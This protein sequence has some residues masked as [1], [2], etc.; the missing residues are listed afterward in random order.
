MAGGQHRNEIKISA[1]FFSR[2][3]L[4]YNITMDRG[5]IVPLALASSAQLRGD[6]LWFWVRV[7]EQHPQITMAANHRNLWNIQAPLKKTC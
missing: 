1:Q 4:K 2:A 3:Y 6:L 5:S 7:A